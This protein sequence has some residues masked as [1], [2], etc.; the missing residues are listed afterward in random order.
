MTVSGGGPHDHVVQFYDADDDLAGRVAGYVL[1]A[2]QNRGVG[3]VV[4]TPAHRAAI[5]DW[6]EQAGVNLAA[7]REQGSYIALDAEETL[8]QFMINGRADAAGFWRV[9]SPLMKTAG[10]RRRKVR[11]FGEMVALLWESG[12]AD[13]AVDLEALWNELARQYSFSLYCAYPAE[14]LSDSEHVHELAEV[15]GAHSGTIT[16]RGRGEDAMSL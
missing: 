5:E 10:R 14:L 2:L 9:I 4:A 6:L 3:I 13:A 7:A 8:S 12:Q 1:G 15:L 16:A 11:V